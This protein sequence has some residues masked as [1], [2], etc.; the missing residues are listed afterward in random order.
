MTKAKV[1]LDQE[2]DILERYRVVVKAFEV[3]R[4]F[5][6]PEGVKARYVLIDLINQVPRLLI[7]NHP[8]HGFHERSFKR[9]II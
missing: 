4:S 8:P 2:F 7:D 1:L 6:F 3:D 9:R 5:K